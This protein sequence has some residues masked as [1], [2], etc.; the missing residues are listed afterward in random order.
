MCLLPKAQAS[1][2][3]ALLYLAAFCVGWDAVLEP[4]DRIGQ[5]QT[6]S[7]GLPLVRE[8]HYCLG[9]SNLGAGLRQ[10]AQ[11]A[12]DTFAVTVQ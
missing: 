12:H 11:K 8:I 3:I 2:E 7:P 6:C 10:G 5:Q 9:G 4:R 1:R